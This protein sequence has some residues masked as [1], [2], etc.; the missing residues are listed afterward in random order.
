MCNIKNVMAATLLLLPLALTPLGANA[1][2]MSSLKNFYKQT[3]AVRAQ[4][5]Q[6]V[7]D[8]QGRKVQEVYGEMQLKRPNKFRWDYSKPFEQQIISDGE[9][10]WLY[11]IELAQVTVRPLG[12]ALGSSPAALL[13]G[14]SNLDKNFKLKNVISTD[15]IDWVSAD[16]NDEESGFEKILIGFKNNL[17]QEMQLVDS[18]G[19]QTKIVFSKLENNPVINNKLFLFKPPA[20]V[21]VV[22]E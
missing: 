17:L 22:G 6:L 15:G 11:D 2:G 4:F 19:H 7:T 5:H 3:Q 16:P 1:D 21:D 12:K 18:F 14:D 10:V 9:R 8:R 13:A 20:N